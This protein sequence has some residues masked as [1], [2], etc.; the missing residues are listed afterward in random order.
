MVQGSLFLV[1]GETA[2]EDLGSGVMRKMYGYDDKIMM[3]KI[4][5]EAGALGVLH[6]HF[7]SQVTYVASGVFEVYNGDDKKTLTTGDGYYIIPHVI[8]G[9]KCIEPGI[10]IDV[11]SPYREDFL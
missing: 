9:V 7:H 11:F 3:T 1:D 5:F 4:K 2:W 8:H 6:E 10:L